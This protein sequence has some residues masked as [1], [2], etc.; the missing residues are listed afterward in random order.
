VK[1]GGGHFAFSQSLPNCLLGYV[2][3][4]TICFSAT[5]TLCAFR[6]AHIMLHEN[7]GN[8]DVVRGKINNFVVV[9]DND[10]PFDIY[11]QVI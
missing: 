5:Q 2:V 7:M 10:M 9:R 4:M 8:D 3:R 6:S 11:K 1:A